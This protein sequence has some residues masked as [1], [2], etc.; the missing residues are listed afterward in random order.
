MPL[1]ALAYETT[2]FSRNKSFWKVLNA[3]FGHRDI[4]GGLDRQAQEPNLAPHQRITILI[5]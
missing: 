2:S 5:S 3:H 1:A 4:F